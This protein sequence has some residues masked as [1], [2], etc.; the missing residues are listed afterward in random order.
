[1][2][3]I[4]IFLLNEIDIK[5]DV[6]SYIKTI[7]KK[8]QL[9][10]SCGSHHTMILDNNELYI[11]GGN[12]F[13]QLGSTDKYIKGFIEN[14]FFKTDKIYSILCKGDY[15]LILTN[16]GLY[17]M[18][19]HEEGQ[20]GLGYIVHDDNTYNT[21]Q[22]IDFFNNME[23]ISVSC[24]FYYTFVLTKNNGIYCMGMN[25]KG[26]LGLGDDNNRYNPTKIN[27]FNLKTIKIISCGRV[28][29]M[30]LTDDGL[31]AMG[32]NHYGQLGKNTNKKNKYEPIKIDYFIDME[33]IFIICHECFTL[34]NTKN[35]GLYCMCENATGQSSNELYITKMVFFNNMKIISISCG[36]G[37]TLI[38]TNQG[39]YGFGLNIYGEIG[40]KLVYNHI[41]HPIEIDFFKGINIISVSCGDNFTIVLTSEGLYGF[42]NNTNG[43]LGL[44]YKNKN[45]PFKLKF[46]PL[47]VF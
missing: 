30:I 11:A 6:K 26:Q 39:L 2:D 4:K 47:L 36:L 29:T 24:G 33:I 3:I 16:K 12:H 41:I 19:N 23:I 42:G 18:G 35:D 45:E 10:I 15:T 38:L 20:F 13:G 1:M 46:K 27:F 17:G 43:Q 14:N 28:H 40:Q 31:Y 25:S 37:Q 22:K 8:F 32:S 34:I 5:T 7:L 9:I 21:P 44:N